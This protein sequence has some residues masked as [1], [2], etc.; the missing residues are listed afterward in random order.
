MD[1]RTPVL[2]GAGTAMQRLDDPVGAKDSVALMVAA[3]DAG[4]SQLLRRAR[5]VLVPKG[6]WTYQ[7]P[8]RLVA[9]AIGNSTAVT[10]LAELGIL[11]TALI[12]HACT[13]IA[14]GDVD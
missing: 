8:G 1:P 10:V 6:S 9:S 3:C 5:L 13:A 12:E 7:D 11:Q 14:R 2:V 4:A